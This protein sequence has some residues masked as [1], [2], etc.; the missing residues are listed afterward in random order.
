[1]DRC[2]GCSF[3]KLGTSCSYFRSSFVMFGLTY[4]IGWKRYV[5]SR[6]PQCPF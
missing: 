1:M 3:S 2:F 4:C 6:F 5:S